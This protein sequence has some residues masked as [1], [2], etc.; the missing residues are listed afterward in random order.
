LRLSNAADRQQVTSTSTDSFQGLLSGL[1]IL[2]TGEAIVVGE[3]VGMPM[4]VQVD[5]LG[6]DRR[7]DSHDPPVVPPHPLPG[8]WTQAR[9]SH[10]DY[11]GLV[12][13]WRTH[14]TRARTRQGDPMERQSVSSSA[15]A[16]VGYDETQ[17]TLEVEFIEGNVYQYY[18]VPESVHAELIGPGSVGTYFSSAIRDVY[19]Y[20]RL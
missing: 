18:G 12:E 1:P 10:T 15:I 17:Q 2:R 4:R 16:R 3:A 9:P 11:A 20:T 14:D 19:P 13:A 8:G 6:D 5:G 7:P